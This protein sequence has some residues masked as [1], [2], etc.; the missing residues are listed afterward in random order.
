[1]TVDAPRARVGGTR[2]AISYAGLGVGPLFDVL[3][4][5]WALVGTGNMGAAL[6]S[7]DEVADNPVVEAFGLFHKALALAYA[8]R[9]RGADVILSGEG[10]TEMRL[11]RRGVVA[12]ATVLS[13]IE[14][15]RGRAGASR[16]H[17][18]GPTLEPPPP[19]RLKNCAPLSRQAKRCPSTAVTT[20]AD[21]CQKCSTP[22]HRTPGRDLAGLHAA[23]RRLALALRPGHIE[24]ILLNGGPPGGT[25]A[26]RTRH[27]GLRHGAS[28][29]TLPT[30]PRSSAAPAPLSGRATPMPPS[31]CS[32]NSRGP[33]ATCLPS[34]SVSEIFLRRLERFDEATPSYD[35]AIEL[36]G[37]A[38]AGG[39][40]AIGWSISR[41]AS[42]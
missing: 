38:A 17:L 19:R 11:T 3:V 31:R 8:G 27:P 7:F 10:G 16:R 24:A 9:F 42:P 32:G 5:G 37:E 1:M 2:S 41:A 23:L 12:H 14:A 15:E 26:I 28:E 20:P 34:T 4:R 39:G 40:G 18:S 29:T 13:Q 36:M 33:T 22:S 6:D 21:G 30:M 25:R 35:R